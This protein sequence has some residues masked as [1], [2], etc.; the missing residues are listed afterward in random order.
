MGRTIMMNSDPLVRVAQREGASDVRMS[1]I[2][3]REIGTYRIIRMSQF[4][5][6]AA[7]A[8]TYLVG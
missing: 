4:S 2:A 8:R 6:V 7:R 1:L 3:V 5:I